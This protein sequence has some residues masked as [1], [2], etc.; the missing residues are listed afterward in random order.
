MPIPSSRLQMEAKMETTGEIMAYA[1]CLGV[2]A[3]VK[4]KQ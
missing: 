2:E 1:N 4:L 3:I